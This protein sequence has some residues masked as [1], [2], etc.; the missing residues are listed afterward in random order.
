MNSF[1]TVI[2]LDG[3]KYL[4]I[5]PM[6]GVWQSLATLF[7]LLINII[8]NAIVLGIVF[9]ILGEK[10]DKK[11]W[12][13]ASVVLIGTVTA[14]FLSFANWTGIIL[15]FLAYA[16]LAKW[17]MNIS[18][19]KAVIVGIIMALIVLAGFIPEIGGSVYLAAESF[20]RGMFGA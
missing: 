6:P 10:L 7:G 11:K 17:I 4:N 15:I 8:V 14:S 20:A 19:V 1:L 9:Y 13:F 2:C 3:K 12:E 16:F 5:V 18:P